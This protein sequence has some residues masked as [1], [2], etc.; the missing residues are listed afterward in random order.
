MLSHR[1]YGQP[2]KK[3]NHFVPRSYLVRFASKSERQVGLY[4]LK[5]GRI[6][7][8]APIRSQCARDYFYTKNPAFEEALS[9]F[10]ASQKKLFNKIIEDNWLPAPE[11][12]EHHELMSL[13]MLQAG[14]TVTA[15]AHDDHILN[16]FGKAVLRKQLEKDE[17]ND[18]LELLPEVRLKVP[19]GV[20]EAMARHLPMYPLLGDL[21]M[22]LFVNECKEDFIT[23]DHPI[24]LCNNL[25]ASASRGA[26]IGYSSRGLIIL[27]PLSPR[28]LLF[29]SDREVYK[30]AKDE[31]DVS[32]IRNLRDAVELNLPQCFNAY[33]NL[34]F[35][36]KEKVPETLAAFGRR[37]ENLRA[38]P[39]SVVEI[40]A[41]STAGRK[42]VLL[43]MPPPNRRM[44]LPASVE[45]RLAA[46]KEKYRKGDA[47]V[48]DPMRVRAVEME[49]DRLEKLREPATEEL[50][51]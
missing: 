40:P 27:F 46:R 11:S 9:R 26:N 14:R 3:N 45:L 31:R 35:A 44:V 20:I 18:L 15:A 2:K 37:R 23:S 21:E 38:P 41:M 34:Y 50:E 28:I 48:R 19:H 16:E 51:E 30:V 25:P 36:N 22:T 6:I 43:T 32:V 1:D 12:L 42:G 17:R 24:A 13:I 39:A 29:L 5:S 4:N 47:F 33:E 8:V 49:L 7:D 10:E